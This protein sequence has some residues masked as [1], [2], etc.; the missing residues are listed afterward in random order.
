M[1]GWYFQFILTVQQNGAVIQRTITEE[2]IHQLQETVKEQKQ[3]IAE[4][5][6]QLKMVQLQVSLCY[7]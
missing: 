2:K 6:L 3:Q 5:Q 4:L 1:G 7:I